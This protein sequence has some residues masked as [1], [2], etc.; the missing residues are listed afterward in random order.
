MAVPATVAAVPASI[1]VGDLHPDVQEHHLFAAFVEFGSIASVRVCRDRVT[2]NSLCYGYVNFRSQQDAIRAIKLRNNS[3][4]NGKVIRVMWL[5]RDPNARKS[6]RGNVFVKN[7]AGSIDNA[8]LHDLFKKYGNILSSKVVM[9]EDGKS[10]GYGFVQFEWEE[11]A[12]NAIEK[13]NGSTVGNKQIYVGK[14]VRKGDRILP[15]YDAKYT[16][17]Y[18]KNLDSD[19]TEAL[20]QEKFSSFGKIISLA[21]SKDDN[22]LSKGFA[23]VNYENPDDAKKAMEAMNGLQ[24][25]SK[26]LYVAR[27]QKKAEREQILH[28][29]FEEKRKE[30]ILK[31]QASNLYVKNIDD[32]VTDKELR[33]LFSSCGTITSVKVMRD[34]KGISK[35]FG[36]VCFSNPEEANKAVMSFNGCT[37]HRKPLYIAIAQRKK[38]RKTQLNLHYAPQQAGLDGSS[39][40]VIPGG[41]PPYFYHSVASLM[42][43]SGLLYQPLGLRSGW[44][45]NDFVPPARSFQHSQVPIVPNFTRHQRQ[46]RGSRMNGNLNSLGKAYSSVYIPQ[47]QYYQAVEY[48]AEQGIPGSLLQEWLL[49]PEALPPSSPSSMARIGKDGASR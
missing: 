36:F 30:Q 33:D 32:D 20:L 10:K 19:I 37:F 41:V 23:F 42:F 5:H 1:Y 9:S 4:L 40:P 13:L 3:Y 24:F 2:M 38:E 26:Y 18:I 16:N 35:G 7:L 44:R 12:N 17:L 39:T 48:S 11:S 6:G 29:Q 14:F 15:G 46:N 45:A 28:R 27:A 31:Y 47:L 49:T 21:I 25:G 43:Q 8:G 22:G 34:D